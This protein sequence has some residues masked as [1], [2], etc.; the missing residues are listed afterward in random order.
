MSAALAAEAPNER[1]AVHRAD[2]GPGPWV[3]RIKGAHPRFG[4]EREFMQPLR[5]YSGARVNMKRQTKGVVLEWLLPP[6]GVYEIRLFEGKRG[7]ER[8]RFY[9]VEDGELVEVSREEVIEWIRRNAR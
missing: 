1:M 9:R 3:A 2:A 4:F 5:D 8:R 6:E 7:V